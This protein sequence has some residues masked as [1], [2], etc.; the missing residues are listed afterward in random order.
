MS[1]GLI[2]LNAAFALIA[3]AAI[4]YVV[5]ELRVPA[6]A[7]DVARRP[8]PE[9]A[10]AVPAAPAAAETPP[11]TYGVVAAR[12]LFSPTR[13]E[14]PPA[15]V[16]AGQTTAKPSLYGI[17]VTDTLHVAYLEDPITKRVAGYRVGDS[18][19]GGKLT[20]IAADFVVLNRPDG[21]VNVRLRDPFKPRSAPAA[22]PGQGGSPVP[23]APGAPPRAVVPSTPG[24]QGIPAVPGVPGAPGVSPT[25]PTQPIP[26]PPTPGLGP[27]TAGPPILP[28]RPLPPNLSRR[29]PPAGT[30]APAQD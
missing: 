5:R 18:V 8:I 22:V 3:L 28:R 1:R 6:P 30:I 21:D 29:L 17:L 11:G 23:A 19:A 12:N 24:A 20:Q 9:A 7:L 26:Q 4:G 10:P 15:P 2:A 14:A 27:P 25:Q 13:T 16:A